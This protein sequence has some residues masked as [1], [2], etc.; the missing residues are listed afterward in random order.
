MALLGPVHQF[1]LTLPEIEK[2]ALADQIRRAVRS[3]PTNIVEGYS[4]RSS[5]KDFKHFLSISMGSANEAVV[6]FEICR[7]I[8]YDTADRCPQF[9]EAYEAIGKQLHLLMA[10][11]RTDGRVPT[12]NI[13]H[14]TSATNGTVRR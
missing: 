13:Q 8:G 3:V 14:P 4:R 5:A 1:A 2:F 7:Q 9:I 12:S 10:N 11:W 6:H